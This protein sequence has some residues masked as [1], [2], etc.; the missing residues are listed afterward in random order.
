MS[1]TNLFTP[2][3]LGSVHVR[4]RIFMPPMHPN[5]SESPNGHYTKRYI[6]YYAERARMESASFLP[7]MSKPK[8]RS[9]RIQQLISSHAWTKQMKSNTSLNS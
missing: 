5:L 9:T 1:Y 6:D 7:V 2:I 3:E 4:N 8:E